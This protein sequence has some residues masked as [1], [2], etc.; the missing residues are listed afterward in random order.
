MPSRML[1]DQDT[2]LDRQE[3]K[4][5]MQEAASRQ[6]WRWA[7][8]ACIGVIVACLSMLLNSCIGWLNLAR[9]HATERVISSR[10]GHLSLFRHDRA[11]LGKI[12]TRLDAFHIHDCRGTCFR[13]YKFAWAKDHILR[14][15][16]AATGGFWA[17]YFT[18][19]GM[20]A[21]YALIAGVVVAYGAPKAAGSGMP[22]IKVLPASDTIPVQST[23]HVHACIATCTIIVGCAGD[24]ALVTGR[25]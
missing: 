17:P 1:L 3:R 10:G 11:V 18:F 25:P 22:E 2:E 9:I 7:L 23:A 5:G 14:G 15:R 19:V 8:V 12:H 21:G 24:K 16:A 4:L 13:M 6:R 20:A